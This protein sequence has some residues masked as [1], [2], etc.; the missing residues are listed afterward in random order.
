LS[1]SDRKQIKNQAPPKTPP[2]LAS[3]SESAYKP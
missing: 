3:K 2:T 1:F